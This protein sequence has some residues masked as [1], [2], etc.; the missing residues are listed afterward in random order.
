MQCGPLRETPSNS[1]VAAVRK[2]D[3]DEYL[4]KFRLDGRGWSRQMVSRFLGAPD[5]TFHNYHNPERP[6]QLYRRV[7]VFQA[8]RTIAF[9][10]AAQKA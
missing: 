8:E 4:S 3:L 9:T 10:D 1:T 5:G 2:K 6:I 7:R